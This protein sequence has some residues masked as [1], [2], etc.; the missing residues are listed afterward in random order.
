MPNPGVRQVNYTRDIPPGHQVPQAVR[1][2][3]DALSIVHTA[4]RK[5]L[6]AL[7]RTRGQRKLEPLKVPGHLSAGMPMSDEGVRRLADIPE[8]ARD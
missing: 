1:D 7:R 5:E 4:Q 2:G 3:L 8:L 6:D